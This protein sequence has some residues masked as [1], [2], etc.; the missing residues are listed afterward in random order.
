M[1]AATSLIRAQVAP[2]PDEQQLPDRMRSKMKE[3]PLIHVGHDNAD[4]VGADH[5]ILQAAV[6]YV[7]GLGG[8][9][10]EIGEGIYE[11]RDSLHLR[12][13][14]HVKGVPGKSILRK[15]KGYRTA[16]ALDGDFGEEQVTLED[17]AGFEI[18]GGIMVTDDGAGGFHTTV[19]RI[20][21]RRGSTFAISNPLMSDCMVS[22]HA[23][24]ATLFPVISGVNCS[25]VEVQDL[26][27]DGN[28]EENFLLNG[29]RGAGIYLYRG[30]GTS[31]RNCVVRNYFGDGISFQ[32]SN[33]VQVTDCVSEGNTHLG[34]HPGSGSQRPI[35]SSNTAR[36]NGE[37]GLFLC[38]RVRHGL[39]ENNLLEN[40]G[41]FGISI[42][43]K[44]TDNLLRGNHIVMNE[45]AGVFFRNEAYG[46][47]GHRNRLEENLIENNGRKSPAPGIRVRGETGGLIFRKNVIR[48]TRSGDQ[49]L[50]TTG[51]RIESQ[52]GQI[53]LDNNSIQAKQNIIDLRQ[54]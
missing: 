52:A 25:G 50:Q 54:Q 38:W 4:F 19:A 42:G 37:D 26:V 17:P 49:A 43:H 29:C 24:A 36:N 31:I 28:K 15:A 53:E 16:L 2:L 9:T 47:A 39:F 22:Q 34:L 21:G 46:M 7:Y 3:K 32:Q 35:V 33:D 5:R 44:D 30:H 20:Q 1:V 51:I 14:V 8:G 13:N 45:E 41:R 27:V 23:Y 10:V 11:M 12:S 18:G 6:D 40:N 48:E